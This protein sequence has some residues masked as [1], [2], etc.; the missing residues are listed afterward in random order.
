MSSLVSQPSTD[1]KVLTRKSEML[2]LAS[3]VTTERN[4]SFKKGGDFL[5]YEKLLERKPRLKELQ[6]DNL[7]PFCGGI[8][9]LTHLEVAAVP[10][11]KDI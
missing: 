5:N 4:G 3:T 11:H 10:T 6:K 8:N 7:G 9:S 1:L 2:T